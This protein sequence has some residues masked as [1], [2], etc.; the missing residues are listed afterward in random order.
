MTGN[1]ISID[2]YK[3]KLIFQNIK[4]IHREDIQQETQLNREV[5]GITFMVDQ[6][7]RT[8][9][10]WKVQINKNSFSEDK[11]LQVISNYGDSRQ[12]TEIAVTDINPKNATMMEMFAGCSYADY[13]IHGAQSA[14]GSFEELKKYLSMAGAQKLC[15]CR[16]SYEELITRKRNW[17]TIVKRMRQEYLDAGLYAQYQSCLH[18]QD[19]FDFYYCMQTEKSEQSCVDETVFDEKYQEI[20]DKNAQKAMEYIRKEWK[21]YCID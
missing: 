11:I 20:E 18:L 21:K 2:F 7:S 15:V 6:S 13:C 14:F 10:A 16:K 12:K 17:E 4:R 19:I 3:Q 8:P 9:Y 1:G 5:I